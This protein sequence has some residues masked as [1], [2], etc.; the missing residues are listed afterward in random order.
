[1]TTTE[2]KIE[3]D[4]EEDEKKAVKIY[5][6]DRLK[7]QPLPDDVDPRAREM[8]LAETDFEDVFGVAKSK[9]MSLP[10]WRKKALKRAA[11]L[12]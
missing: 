4:L 7:S 8:H 11:G 1:M 5:S 2:A 9:F 12:F 3:E 10:E 6:I